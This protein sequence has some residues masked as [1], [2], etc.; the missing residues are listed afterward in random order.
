MPYRNARCLIPAVGWYEWKPVESADEATGEIRTYKQ[1]YFLRIDREAPVC[2]AG[3]MSTLTPEGG[4][5]RI[6]CAFLTRAPS[7]SAAVVHDRMPVILKESAHKEWLDPELKDAERVAEIIATKSLDKVIHH[8][9]GTRLNSAKT[10][11]ES[12]IEPIVETT[13]TLGNWR[14]LQRSVPPLVCMPLP[15]SLTPARIERS[16]GRRVPGD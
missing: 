8:A 6:T 1:R 14:P 10:D 13:S 15:R 5:P 12:L 9:V 3:L 2:F 16:S 4:E 11:D 7:P